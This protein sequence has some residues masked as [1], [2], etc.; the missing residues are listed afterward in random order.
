MGHDAQR[1]VLGGRSTAF[2]EMISRIQLVL[3]LV[4]PDTAVNKK[5]MVGTGSADWQRRS[6]NV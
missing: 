2:R 4:V 6:E 3:A 5:A 1:F